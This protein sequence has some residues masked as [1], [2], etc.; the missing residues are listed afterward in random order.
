MP[1]SGREKSLDLCDLEPITR[2]T[3]QDTICETIRINLDDRDVRTW[4]SDPGD[5]ESREEP[6]V[7]AED[8]QQNCSGDRELAALRWEDIGELTT[9]AVP[10]KLKDYLKGVP[11]RVCFNKITT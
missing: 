10:R 5:D 11:G 3:Y 7:H 1:T 6:D 4:D 2:F 9:D 8:E